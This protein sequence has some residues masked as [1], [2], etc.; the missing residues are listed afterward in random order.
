MVGSFNKLARAQWAYQYT[1]KW[2][3]LKGV[4]AT[5]THIVSSLHRIFFI[6][7]YSNFPLIR[8]P[9]GPTTSSLNR[10]SVFTGM[11]VNSDIN[12]VW[13]KQKRWSLC[14]GRS[15]YWVVLKAFF[16]MQQFF[17]RTPCF[18]VHNF[19]LHFEKRESERRDN[20]CS[21]FLSASS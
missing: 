8:P 9:S 15:K 14:F 4:I 19:R 13:I 11:L 20:V 1:Y 2:P 16:L 21:I 12:W 7:N 6:F 18:L 17:K 3:C 10:G 5:L